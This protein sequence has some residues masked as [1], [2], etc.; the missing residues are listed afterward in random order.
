MLLYLKEIIFLMLWKIQIRYF[1]SI[2][3]NKGVLSADNTYHFGSSLFLLFYIPLVLFVLC[4]YKATIYSLKIQS[5]PQGID[6]C[7]HKFFVVSLGIN[8]KKWNNNPQ[9]GDH[10]K[11]LPSKWNHWLSTPDPGQIVPEARGPDYLCSVTFSFQLGLWNRDLADLC[12]IMSKLVPVRNIAH[13]KA[14]K[15]VKNKGSKLK[16]SS[17]TCSET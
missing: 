7:S 4:S 10:F 11:A 2:Y 1:L 5:S 3:L 14:A 17:E 6:L 16:F 8:L 12:L 9:N 15:S 13:N